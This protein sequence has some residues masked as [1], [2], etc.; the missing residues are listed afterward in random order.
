MVAPPGWAIVPNAYANFETGESGYFI[1]YRVYQSGD[2][3]TTAAWTWPTDTAAQIESWVACSYESTNTAGPID[4]SNNSISTTNGLV[5]TALSATPSSSSDM[6]TMWFTNSNADP[7][8]TLSIGKIEQ[9]MTA[10]G[11]VAL[12]AD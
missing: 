11:Q 3:T 9:N 2:P 4:A 7:G 8:A 12:V 1:Y 10:G 5:A 6:L